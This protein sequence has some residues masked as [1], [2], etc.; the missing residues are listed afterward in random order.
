MSSLKVNLKVKVNSLSSRTKPDVEIDHAL[1][2]ESLWRMSKL[3]SLIQGYITQVITQVQYWMR[4]K[5]T[6]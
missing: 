1:G 2:T 4:T 6:S 5:R 3:N